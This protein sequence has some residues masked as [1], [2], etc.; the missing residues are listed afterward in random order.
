[1]VSVGAGSQLQGLVANGATT[2]LRAQHATANL[3]E[4]AR[5]RTETCNRETREWTGSRNR[6]YGAFTRSFA[7]PHTVD[8]NNVQAEYKDGVLTVKLPIR[9]EAKPR[10]I[11]VN[12]AA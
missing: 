4:F 12:V 5:I 7:L 2:S 8:S 1:V 11:K 6:S 3:D 10:Q 9:E